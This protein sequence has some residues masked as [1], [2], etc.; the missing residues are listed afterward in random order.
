MATSRRQS[1]NWV[2]WQQVELSTLISENGIIM[3]DKNIQI[4]GHRTEVRAKSSLL[5]C[6][7]SINWHSLIPSV[8]SVCSSWVTSTSKGF[9]CSFTQLVNVLV[10][11]KIHLSSVPRME[12]AA[13]PSAVRAAISAAILSMMLSP[14]YIQ[15]VTIYSPGKSW[16]FY[17]DV[18]LCN[19]KKQL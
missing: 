7:T 10:W 5:T 2:L 11:I 16:I 3:A 8:N 18:A 12:N 15:N 19:W 17:N 4:I 9:S 14:I 1:L 13:C 6:K